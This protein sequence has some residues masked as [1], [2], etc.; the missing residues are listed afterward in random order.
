MPNHVKPRL[1]TI[2]PI[3][4]IFG[5]Q[6]H[7]NSIRSTWIQYRAL[8]P[9]LRL[10]SSPSS[11]TQKRETLAVY[12]AVQRAAVRQPD[13]V[14]RRF[15][16][17][18]VWEKF[19]ANAF[20]NDELRVRVLLEEARK[21]EEVLAGAARG[22]TKNAAAVLEYCVARI[23]VEEG[24]L[25]S[26][27]KT[28]RLSGKRDKSA[29]RQVNDLAGPPRSETRTFKDYNLHLSNAYTLADP[30]NRAH[31][32]SRAEKQSKEGDPPSKFKNWVMPS[33]FFRF[34]V[35]YAPVH[36][37]LADAGK[38]RF[39]PLPEGTISGAPLPNRRERNL[40]RTKIKQILALSY[41]PIDSKMLTYLVHSVHDYLSDEDLAKWTT[42]E[43]GEY[44]FVWDR[45]QIRMPR[46]H[47]IVLPA[48]GIRF[49]KR[50]MVS[51]LEQVYTMK[52][53]DIGNLSVVLAPPARISISK[54][55]ID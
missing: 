6:S 30:E 36:S 7:P 44:F 46:S 27:L 12:R 33:L 19:L 38:L 15:L 52:M 18:H 5:P 55:I 25:N 2:D 54:R 24:P 23:N 21:Q 47:G 42:R 51:L 20:C 48:K 34:L 28:S 39:E 9:S 1:P 50:R 41:R 4:Y 43:D 53:D 3:L 37:R 11:P 22:D 16:R 10:R 40:V 17:Q 26:I 32:V 13:P 31:F 45:A 14:C 49:Y 29:V 8:D 35:A